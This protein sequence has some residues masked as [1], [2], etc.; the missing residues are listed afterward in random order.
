M[1]ET[2]FIIG[3]LTIVVIYLALLTREL[4]QK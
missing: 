4:W 1:K 2:L 3:V